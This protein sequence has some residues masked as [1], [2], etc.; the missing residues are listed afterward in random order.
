[1]QVL[2]DFSGRDIRLT[3]ER[4]E[5]IERRPEMEGQVRRIEETLVQP[6]EVRKSDQDPSV[7]LYHKRYGE[8]PVT[9]KYLL[10]VVKVEVDSPF[11]ITSFFTDGIKSG[12]PV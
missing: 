9:E 8:T 7:Y 11:V 3:D 12:A 4:R 10:V 5:H 2:R 6:D 1:M